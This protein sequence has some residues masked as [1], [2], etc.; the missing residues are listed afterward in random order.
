MNSDTLRT[1]TE[2]ELYKI[3]AD[4]TKERDAQRGKVIYGSQ[5]NK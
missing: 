3:W 5:E 1:P 4:R 2:E